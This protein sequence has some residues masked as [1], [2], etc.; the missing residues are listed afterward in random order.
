MEAWKPKG[1][2]DVDPVTPEQALEPKRMENVDPVMLEEPTSSKKNMVQ[3]IEVP[4]HFKTNESHSLKSAKEWLQNLDQL[5]EILSII[6]KRDNKNCPQIKIAILDTG[7]TKE[8]DDEVNEYIEEYKDF[9]SGEDKLQQDGTG[10]GSSILRLLLKL[11]DDVKVFVGRVFERDEADDETE[12]VMAEAIM[13]AKVKWKVDIICIPSGFNPYPPNQRIRDELYDAVTATPVDSKTLI[14]A[15]AS[16]LGL[17]SEITYP[18]CISQSSKLICLFSTTGDGDPES[19]GF[20]PAAVPNTYNFALLGEGIKIDEGNEKLVRGTSYSTAIAAAIA[21]YV[22]GFAGHSGTKDKIRDVRYPRE[23]EGMTSV[24]ASMTA[25]IKN[26]YHIL[27]PWKLMD[28]YQ[29]T[30]LSKKERRQEICKNL[31]K[32]LRKRDSRRYS[33]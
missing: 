6:G 9:A 13:H 7:I 17:S 21:A 10:H 18:G 12:R 33:Y 14:F 31:S 1:I 4:S 19:P 11:N 25:V 16:N 22:M 29:D 8:Y 3:V 26:R 2:E 24:F 20:N 27:K 23:V 32:A 28:D 5:T 15:A 30:S